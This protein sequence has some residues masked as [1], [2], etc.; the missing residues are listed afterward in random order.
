MGGAATPSPATIAAAA[1]APA[2]ATAAPSPAPLAPAASTAAAS[3]SPAALLKTVRLRPLGVD[4]PTSGATPATP[5]TP[6][7]RPPLATV[8]SVSLR[9][10]KQNAREQQALRT[11]IQSVQRAAGESIT[12]VEVSWP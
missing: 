1:I 8:Q 7:P 10:G 6:A 5:A 11:Q 12:A 3:P 2:P 9:L 4:T